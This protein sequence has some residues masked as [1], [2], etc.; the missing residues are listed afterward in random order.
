MPEKQKQYR[1]VAIR[2]EPDF[3]KACK[4]AAVDAGIS[5]VEWCRQAL[6]EKLER[7][8]LGKGK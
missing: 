3:H 5:F 1:Q 7:Q 4:H 2:V 6:R 8:L